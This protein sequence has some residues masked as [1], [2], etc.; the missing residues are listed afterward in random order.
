MIVDGAIDKRV[1]VPVRV[2]TCGLAPSLSVTVTV[3][4][5]WPT[6]VGLNATLMAQFAPGATLVP[7]VLLEMKSPLTLMEDIVSVAAL[8][9]VRVMVFMGLLFLTN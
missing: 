7:Q 2:T 8:W 4:Y 5:R 6:T 1:P 3:P 9:L